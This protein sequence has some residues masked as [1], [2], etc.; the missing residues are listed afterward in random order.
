MYVVSTHTVKMMRMRGTEY[1]QEK[2]IQNFNKKTRRMKLIGRFR[3]KEGLY[4]NI[5]EINGL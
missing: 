1:V 3:R 5:F 2:R 4:K